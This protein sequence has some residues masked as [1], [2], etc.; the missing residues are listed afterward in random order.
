VQF[1]DVAQRTQRFEIEGEGGEVREPLNNPFEFSCLA[2]SPDGERVALT[3]STNKLQ[4]W[5]LTTRAV[6]SIIEV[7][8]GGE[9]FCIA[10]SPDGR[11]LATGSKE[12][13]AVL[14]DIGTGQRVHT[15][16]G[17]E[18]LVGSLAFSRE[19]KLLATGSQPGIIKVWNV[20]SGRTV[21]QYQGGTAV[22]AL[23]FSPDDSILATAHFDGRLILWDLASKQ[24]RILA[25]NNVPV[26]GVAFSKDGKTIAASDWLGV[27]RLWNVETGKEIANFRGRVVAFSPDDKVLAIGERVLP[28]ANTDRNRK[29]S[30]VFLYRA[31]LL[32]E[33]TAREAGVTTVASGK[34]IR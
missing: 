32:E 30:R 22:L 24:H 16:R 23:A 2:F 31:P 6:A 10:W 9:V 15:L 26:V 14:W 4:I 12:R 1:W 21:S 27:T 25:P 7:Q 19:G 11:R 13:I 28:P 3:R 34:V 20:A 17:H 29:S 33:I 8:D 5:D 18:G